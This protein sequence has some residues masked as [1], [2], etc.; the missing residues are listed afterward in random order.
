MRIRVISNNCLNTT[1]Y[2]ESLPVLLRVYQLND[3]TQFTHASFEQLW[4]T[5]A[6][7]LG[8]TFQSRHDYTVYPGEEKK[9]SFKKESET[10]YIGVFATFRK[11]SREA[12]RKVVKVPP[13]LIPSPIVVELKNNEL[14]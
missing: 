11:P 10:Q 9:I 3:E 4:K 14:R 5:D 7:T 8:R 1:D 12:W 2:Q 6:N 13:G